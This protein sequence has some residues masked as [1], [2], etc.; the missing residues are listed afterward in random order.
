MSQRSALLLCLIA[1][2]ALAREAAATPPRPADTLRDLVTQTGCVAEG[3]VSD[4]TLIYDAWYGPRT[5]VTL[6]NVVARLGICPAGP[7][8]LVQAGGQ[9]PDGRMLSV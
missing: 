9:L 3:D 8:T 5:R 7:I 4:I 1:V 2:L 6:S